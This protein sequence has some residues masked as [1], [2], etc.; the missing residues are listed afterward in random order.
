VAFPPAMGLK[1]DSEN[2]RFQTNSDTIPSL[3]HRTIMVG[4]TSK[5]T[6]STH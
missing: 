2:L 4:K 5:I 3:K 6:Q 1:D